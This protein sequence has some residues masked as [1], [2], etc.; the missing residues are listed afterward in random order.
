MRPDYR[1]FK[2]TVLISSVLLWIG[3][4]ITIGKWILSKSIGEAFIG[5]LMFIALIMC[6]GYLLLW[7]ESGKG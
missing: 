1:W 5:A 6:T 2:K 7:Y 3:F 4:V